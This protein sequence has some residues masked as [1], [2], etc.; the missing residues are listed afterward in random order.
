MTLHWTARNKENNWMKCLDLVSTKLT[1]AS[2][3]ALTYVAI[4]DF[5]ASNNLRSTTSL[6]DVV[7]A[8]HDKYCID[9]KNMYFDGLCHALY[10]TGHT[11]LVDKYFKLTPSQHGSIMPKT[12]ALF[13]ASPP[14]ELGVFEYLDMVKLSLEGIAAAQGILGDETPVT[15]HDVLL[16]RVATEYGID[17]VKEIA[18][19]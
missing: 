4:I 3:S 18:L 10:E 8:L 7:W 2:I 5:G 11:E 14:K 19:L 15:D 16:M 6:Y 9:R 17:R 13:T 12:I 1:T